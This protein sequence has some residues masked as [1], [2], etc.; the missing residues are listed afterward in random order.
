MEI[1]SAK[2]AHDRDRFDSAKL[3][4]SRTRRSRPPKGPDRLGCVSIRTFP[5]EGVDSLFA[6]LTRRKAFGHLY[7]GQPCD[8][9]LLPK[10][11]R[12]DARKNTTALEK[13]MLAELRR[14]GDRL[15][16]GERYDDWDLL[17]VAQHHGMSTRLLDWTSNPL[18]ALWFA[19]QRIEG[20]AAYVYILSLEDEE[21][22]TLD[23]TAQ[24]D[25]FGIRNT[26]IFKPTLNNA[27]IIAQHGWFTAHRWSQ[28]SNRF[29]ALEENPEINRW[30]WRL[31]I[32]ATDAP[33]L[34]D[35]LDAF[36]VNNHSLFPD[37][38]GA[39]KHINW[40]HDV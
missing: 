5:F 18:A 15:L 23:R 3:R 39:C 36:G 13:R 35:M 29:V 24:R 10:I 26:R 22:L 20:K 1:Y 25:P 14:R 16:V 34:L 37:I 40:M 19:C 6:S 2:L 33:T 21:T 30:L 27:R 28:R 31:E 7:R 12:A 11:A 8:K 4:R 9:P 38:E 32:A 17:V